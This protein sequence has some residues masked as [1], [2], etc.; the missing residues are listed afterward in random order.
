MYYLEPFSNSPQ[1][2][3]QYIIQIHND[4][5]S[6]KTARFLYHQNRDISDWYRYDEAKNTLSLQPDTLARVNKGKYIVWAGNGQPIPL[7]HAL[8]IT[9]SLKA[10]LPINITRTE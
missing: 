5:I 6:T 7:L 1:Y 8:K 4:E 3:G 10:M 2:G 9:A